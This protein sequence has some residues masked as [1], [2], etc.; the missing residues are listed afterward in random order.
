MSSSQLTSIF[1]RGVETANQMKM[2]VLDVFHMYFTVKHDEGLYYIFCEHE[3]LLV[4]NPL[5]LI[6]HGGSSQLLVTGG[7]A[8]LKSDDFRQVKK[9]N[10]KQRC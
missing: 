5:N 6:K 10:P 2:V 7:S 9:G 1:F 3:A 8:R 4:L